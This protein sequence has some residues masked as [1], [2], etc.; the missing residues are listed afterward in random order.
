MAR[1]LLTGTM[2]L[3][4]AGIAVLPAQAQQPPPPRERIVAEMNRLH[5]LCDEGYKPACIQFGI[6]LGKQQQRAAQWRRSNPEW[7]WWEPWIER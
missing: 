4:L 7:W 5:R 2:A 6:M 1:K 3:L